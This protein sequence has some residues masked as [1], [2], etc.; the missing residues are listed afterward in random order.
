MGEHD[1]AR[2][3]VNDA[4]QV[5]QSI[6]QTHYLRYWLISSWALALLATINPLNAVLWFAG[7]LA[8]GAIRSQFEKH[9]AAKVGTEYGL[10]FPAVATATTLAW[11]A[12]PVLAWFSGAPFGQPLAVGLLAS[13]YILVFSQMRNSPRQAMVISSPYTLAALVMLVSAWGTPVFLPLMGILPF[14]WSSLFVLT[15]MTL[16]Q[17]VKIEAFQDHQAH[18]IEELEESRDKADAANRAKSAFLAVI[19]HELRTP[20]NGVLGAAQLLTST[21]LD[22]T[23]KEYVAIVRN[24]GDNLMA[25][26]NDI[27][28]L[29]RIEADR[30]ELESTE[31]D[32]AE[33]SA[34]FDR[35]WSGRASEKDVRFVVE[36]DPSTPASVLGDPARTA[37]IVHNLL[38]NAVK[39]TEEGEVRL[40][41]SADRLSDRRARLRF[42]VADT[43]PGIA[44]EHLEKLFRPFTQVDGSSTRRFGGAGIGL[45]L[46]QKL[47]QMMDGGLEVESEPGKGSVFTFALEVDVRAWH[48]A[49]VQ[50]P[51]TAEL[52]QGQIRV[53]VVEDHPVNRMIVEAWLASAGH[54]AVAAENGQ[55][56]LEMAMAQPFDLI[57]MDVN[58]PVMDGLT[59]TQK[60]REA[61]GPNRDTPVVVLSASARSEDHEAG[62]SAG[63]DAYL[64]KPIDFK[65]FA[66]MLG[67]LPGGRE[68]LR[69]A[70]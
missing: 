42:Q 28:D 38:S 12:A 30:L 15:I 48:A 35:T 31:I 3:R 63:A 47:A 50:A 9:L 45:T 29:T 23:Q 19:S 2:A 58:M 57:L 40:T 56:G 26:L 55:I 68:G 52:E 11:A 36:I 25:L 54:V 1:K 49:Q 39:F 24:S 62:L 20:M 32:L 60:L 5:L 33:F 4:A 37:Q 43:G 13:G 14:L 70:A 44:P 53:L 61:E 7:T 51:V 17:N 10:I 66:E 64:N 8:A 34:R 69:E 18:L 21:R 16:S 65:L 67:R 22:P 41:V 59:A 27:L 6:L 46:S